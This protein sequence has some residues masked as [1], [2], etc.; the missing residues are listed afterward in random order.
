MAWVKIDANFT[1][2]PAILECGPTAAWLYV[3]GL[4]Y[5]ARYE[6]DGFLP[7][8]QIRRLA[9]VANPGLWADQLVLAGLWLP[10]ANGFQIAATLQWSC[11]P[12]IPIQEE[13]NSAVYRRW[14]QQVLARDEFTCQD[15]GL[16]GENLHAHHIQAFAE[17]PE[18]RLEL[19]NGVTLCADC[20]GQRHGRRLA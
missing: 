5:T 8:Q 1:D 17:H 12:D 16:A 20:H 2:H 3:C 9:D 15:C 10:T 7:H 13:R 11:H 19:S 6:T 4:A 14:R 18:L